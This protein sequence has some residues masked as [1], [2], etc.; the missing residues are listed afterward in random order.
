MVEGSTRRKSVARNAKE[1]PLG[2]GEQAMLRLKLLGAR[3]ERMRLM[4][5]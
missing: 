4:I 3:A 1:N 5:R 2:A